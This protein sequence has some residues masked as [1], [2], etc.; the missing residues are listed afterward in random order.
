MKKNLNHG[1]TRIDTD[2]EPFRIRVNPCPSVVSFF[3]FLLACA[4]AQAAPK[5]IIL[6][7]GK[8]SHGPGDHE[9][10]AG[11][12]LLKKCLDAVPDVSSVVYSNGWPHMENAFD[13]ADAVLIY[14]DGGAG[15]PAIKPDRMK[16]IDELAAKGVGIGC[17]HYGV[18]VPKGDPAAAMHRW[19][20]GYYEHLFSVNPM[21]SPEFKSFPEHPVTRGVQPFSVLD[22]WYFNMRWRADMKGLTHI[23]VAK[24]ADEVRK[25]PY[26]YPKGPY[27]HVVEASGRDEIMMWV[28]ERPGGGR[29]FGFTGGHRHVNW[30]NENFRKVVLNALLWIAKADVPAN[31]VKCEISQE[32]LKANL[33]PKQKK[34]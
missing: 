11:C 17:A 26:V 25:G 14:A 8:Q 24:P 21:W 22:E 12:L 32:E 1:W 33:D 23:L 9:F 7:A 20:G 10:R 27:P 18:E 4:I 2:K 19:I 34:N 28:Y 5:Q 31:G 6:I 30:G 16:I 3:S 15:H 29:G 13:K